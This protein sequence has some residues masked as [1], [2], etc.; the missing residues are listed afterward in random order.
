MLKPMVG[1][2]KTNNNKKM[3]KTS[4]YTYGI[5]YKEVLIE[6]WKGFEKFIIKNLVLD[7]E[8]K[9]LATTN[10]SQFVSTPR[11]VRYP[12]RPVSKELAEEILRDVAKLLP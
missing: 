10:S 4:N 6:V 3:K 5:R 8:R 11:V 9:L 2:S 7:Y 12:K 1:G